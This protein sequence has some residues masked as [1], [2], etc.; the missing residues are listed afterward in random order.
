MCPTPGCGCFP[1]RAD[2]IEHHLRKCP[3]LIERQALAARGVWSPGANKGDVLDTTPAASEVSLDSEAF[4]LRV[5]EAH[6]RAVGGALLHTAASESV[7]DGSTLGVNESERERHRVQREAI[8][9]LM[10]SRGCLHGQCIMEL[11]AGNAALSL[12]IARQANMVPATEVAPASFILV[13]RMRPRAH[14]DGLLKKL[15]AYVERVRIGI[16]DLDLAGLAQRAGPAAEHGAEHGDGPVSAACSRPVVVAKHLCGSATDFALRAVAAASDDAHGRPAAVFLMTCCHHRC[17]W[18]AYPNR[19]FLAELGFVSAADFD[20]LCRASS[21]ASEAH[22]TS[23][24]ARTGRMAKDLLDMGRC[25]FLRSAG[26][27]CEL[28]TVVDGSITPENV[29]LVGVDT[30]MING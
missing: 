25:A 17:E 13:D 10:L 19:P 1:I 9:S 18:R 22:D 14:A 5:A 16:E 3:K 21:R 24:R 6:R 15:G 26:Y 11:G 28:V 4:V 2:R 20:V 27:D 30:S 12:A 29:V 7:P 23:V 8:A